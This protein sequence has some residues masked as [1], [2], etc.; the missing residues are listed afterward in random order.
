MATSDQTITIEHDTI[1]A[2]AQERQ[3]TPTKQRGTGQSGWDPAILNIV[4]PGAESDALE[5]IEWEEWFEHFE[6]QQ[7]AAVLPAGSGPGAVARIVRRDKVV[8]G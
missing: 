7:L 4:L 5:P 3:A 6:D 1:S 8:L 2:W